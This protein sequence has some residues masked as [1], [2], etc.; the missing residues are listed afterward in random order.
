MYSARA[1]AMPWHESSGPCAT[2]QSHNSMT[3][4]TLGWAG[5]LRGQ[6]QEGPGRSW[7]E[8]SRTA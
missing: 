6:G 3:I 8:A 2:H 5:M 1:E 7:A 4:G